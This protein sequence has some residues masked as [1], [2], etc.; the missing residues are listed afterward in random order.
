LQYLRVFPSNNLTWWRQFK[1]VAESG[2]PQGAPKNAS[3]LAP[4]THSALG[5]IPCGLTVTG[6]KYPILRVFASWPGDA[7][8]H[9]SKKP[10]QNADEDR[11]Y[12]VDLHPLATL[13][14]DNFNHMS[15]SMDLKWFLGDV[16]QK[17]VIHAKRLAGSMGHA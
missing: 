1:T 4:R 15:K 9:R 14:L 2:F 7:K 3:E 8:L 6:A 11:R 5:E 17:E 12:D 10:S 16:E 13:H